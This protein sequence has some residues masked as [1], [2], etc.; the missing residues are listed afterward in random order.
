MTKRLPHSGKGAEP[1]NATTVLH[2]VHITFRVDSDAPQY[3]VI[4]PNDIL[5][6]TV[7][8]FFEQRNDDLINPDGRWWADT[9]V[10]NLGSHDNTTITI[11]V[12]FDPNQ[13]SNVEGQT[14]PQSFYAALNHV[15]WIG[16]TC[17][18]QYFFGHGVALGS[19]AATYILVDFRVE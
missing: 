1:F 7:R 6:A 3:E 10:Y 2:S 5:P 12:S 13:W 19:G 17:G 8:I 11:I 4:D 16:V 18:G 15:G 14:D 9:S